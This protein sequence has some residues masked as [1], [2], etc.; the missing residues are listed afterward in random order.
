M[1]E[2]DSVADQYE[3]GPEQRKAARAFI[4][5]GEGKKL[6]S[7]YCEPLVNAGAHPLTVLLSLHAIN[8]TVHKKR[9][10]AQPAKGPVQS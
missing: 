1:D 5:V 2:L 10:A 3:L 6:V 9:Q 7:D 4:D 8:S